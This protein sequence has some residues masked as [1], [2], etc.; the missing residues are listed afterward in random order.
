MSS[1]IADMLT[2]AFQKI[3]VVADGRQPTPTQSARGLTI[4]ND[5]MADQQADGWH[6]GWWPQSVVTNLAP[7]RDADIGPVKLVLCAWLAPAYGVTIPPA[8]DPND[9]SQLPN[10]IKD[11]MR[12]LSKRSLLNTEAD[13]GELQRPQG[14]PWGGP[15]WL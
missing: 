3:G 12:R 9:M 11:A 7:L 2:E 14:G 5:N 10:Q 8:T 13:L 6:L 1:T 4:L 15:N